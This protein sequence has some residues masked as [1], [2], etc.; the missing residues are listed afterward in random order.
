[1]RL[2]VRSATVIVSGLLVISGTAAAQ[3]PAAANPG[4]DTVQQLL[5]E[6]R[7]LRE[8]VE[9][10]ASDNTALQLVTVRAAMQ[11]ERLYRVSRDVDGLRTRLSATSQ[12]AQD[13]AAAL[14]QFESSV[15][16]E[17]DAGR[18]QSLQAELPAMR[19]RVQVLQQA[20]QQLQQQESAMSDSL[21]AE[22]G[23]WQAINARL[24]DLERRLAS[25]SR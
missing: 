23:R 2:F 18:R 21:S 12:E 5:A 19:R 11:E 24:D 16:D 15:A 9:R 6:V 4:P 10:A 17:V 20:E 1:M 7:Q 25:R 22:E 8:A 13:A 14:K 3:P